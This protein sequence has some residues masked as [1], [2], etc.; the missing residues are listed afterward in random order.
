MRKWAFKDEWLVLAAVTPTAG[1]VVMFGDMGGN[2]RVVD[3]DHG[4]ELCSQRFDSAMAGGVITYDTGIG[5]RIAVVSGMTS[6]IWPTPRVT[7]KLHVL[8]LR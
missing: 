7:A 3:S 2:F 1:G 6:P 8:G 4:N 5:Q